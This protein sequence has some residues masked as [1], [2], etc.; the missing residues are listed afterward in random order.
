MRRH[1]KEG[2]Q[3]GRGEEAKPLKPDSHQSLKGYLDFLFIHRTVS[4]CYMHF[5]AVRGTI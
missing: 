4:K 2:E 5:C 1:A 3:E